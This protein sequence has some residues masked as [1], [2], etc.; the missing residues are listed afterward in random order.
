MQPDRIMRRDMA[1]GRDKAEVVQS[2]GNVFAD[3]GLPNAE[4][5]QTKARLT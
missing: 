2:S 3:L 5:K 4:K 1:R